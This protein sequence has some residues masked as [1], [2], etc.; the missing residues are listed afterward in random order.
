MRLADDFIP[1]CSVLVVI[2]VLAYFFL[3]LYKKNL[4][5]ITKLQSEVTVIE[6][7]ILAYQS[8]LLSD[9]QELKEEMIRKFSSF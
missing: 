2:E 8:A 4:D 7:R 3:K 9:N 1:R 5:N 6:N